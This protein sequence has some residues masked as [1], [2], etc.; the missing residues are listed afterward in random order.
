MK[1]FVSVSLL[2]RVPIKA[3]STMH[4]SEQEEWLQSPWNIFLHLKK[5]LLIEVKE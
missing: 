1:A 5:N 2:N 3:C 4:M